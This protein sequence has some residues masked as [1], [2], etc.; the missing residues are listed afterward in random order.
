VATK[1]GIRCWSNVES[2]DRDFHVSRALSLG[3]R[4]LQKREAEA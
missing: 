1:R 3:G 2:F 4:L